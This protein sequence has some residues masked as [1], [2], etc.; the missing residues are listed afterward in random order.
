MPTKY[1]IIVS[2]DDGSANVFAK[3]IDKFCDAKSIAASIDA[4]AAFGQKATVHDYKEN[5]PTDF[6]DLL[7]SV[8][9]LA[10]N[11]QFAHPN[12]IEHV[13]KQ[14]LSELQRLMKDK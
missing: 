11:A 9:W 1:M 4:K 6:K 14:A 10:H 13:S 12:N 2:N 7:K 3:G 5:E 8:E